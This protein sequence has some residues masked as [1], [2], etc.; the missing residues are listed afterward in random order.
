MRKESKKKKEMDRGTIAKENYQ[1]VQIVAQEMKQE[2]EKFK[3]DIV[4]YK[5]GQ[6][7]LGQME[8]GVTKDEMSKKASKSTACTTNHG[9]HQICQIQIKTGSRQKFYSDMDLSH[10]YI[11][12]C[13]EDT[14]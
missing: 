8:V 2:S 9:L 14:V 11:L 5:N 12:K 10:T 13:T 1:M 4:L 7:L 3:T 6:G